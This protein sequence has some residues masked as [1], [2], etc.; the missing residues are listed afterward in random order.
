MLTMAQ[1]IPS[2]LFPRTLLQNVTGGCIRLPEA[3]Q[4]FLFYKCKMHHMVAPNQSGP[5]VGFIG[6]RR[7]Q[8]LIWGE[9][10]RKGSKFQGTIRH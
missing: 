3:S 4:K 5:Q 2:F 1:G 8:D 6:G 10:Y 7:A 9:E